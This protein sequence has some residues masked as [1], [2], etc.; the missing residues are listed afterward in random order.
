MVSLCGIHSIF[1][2]FSLESSECGITKYGVS[3]LIALSCCPSLSQGQEVV[4]LQ[5]LFLLSLHPPTDEMLLL[6]KPR[7][8]KGPAEVRSGSIGP[9]PSSLLV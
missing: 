6:E 3:A 2:G 4:C 9:D 5:C 7:V 8:G 1:E